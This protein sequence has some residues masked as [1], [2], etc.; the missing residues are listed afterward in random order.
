MMVIGIALG[1]S[2]SLLLTRWISSILF[3]VSRTSVP[4]YAAVCLLLVVVTVIAIAVPSKR[5]MR[6]DPLAALRDS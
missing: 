4:I 6:V 3:G 1:V 2:G 5:A